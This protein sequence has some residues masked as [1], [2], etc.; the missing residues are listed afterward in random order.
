MIFIGYVKPLALPSQ[1]A[2][3]ILNETLTLLS[4]YA[5]FLFSEFVPNPETRY[6]NGWGLIFVTLSIVLINIVI[7]VVN[8][9]LE[10]KSN[11]RKKYYKARY[12]KLVEKKKK[13]EERSQALISLSN[14]AQKNDIFRQNCWNDFA[15]SPSP[16]KNPSLRM[17]K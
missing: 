3:E 7:L 4:T 15:Q 13:D 9:L 17:D 6:T 10:M 5:L 11:T 14:E 1:N 8:T 2:K 12:N 16:R